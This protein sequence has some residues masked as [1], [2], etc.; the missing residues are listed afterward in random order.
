M[1]SVT[2]LIENAEQKAWHVTGNLTSRA[3]DL[4]K[5]KLIKRETA[6]NKW[7]VSLYVLSLTTSTLGIT[8][9]LHLD[10]NSPSCKRL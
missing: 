5:H 8:P 4:K 1:L 2:L 3:K 6:V 9:P 10:H 7:I